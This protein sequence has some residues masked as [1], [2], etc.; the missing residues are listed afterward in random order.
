MRNAFFWVVGVLLLACTVAVCADAAPVVVSG[1]QSMDFMAFVKDILIVIVT[2]FGAVLTASLKWIV[3]AILKHFGMAAD[4]AELSMITTAVDSGA[5]WATHWAS[6]QAIQP[7]HNA[8]VDQ[9][10]A[11]ISEVLDDKLVQT[12]GIVPL[13]NMI[14]AKIASLDTSV[15]PAA[16]VAAPMATA[17]VK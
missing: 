14:S 13:R 3:P 17:T 9:G 1:A 6:T 2:V 5:N 7:T 11:H 12:Y 10:F 4:S 15:Q 8:M 16:T